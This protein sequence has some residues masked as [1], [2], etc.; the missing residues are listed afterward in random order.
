MQ[1]LRTTNPPAFQGNLG[2][3]KYFEGWYFKFVSADGK[4]IYSII[5]GISLSKDPHAFIQI[6][7]GKTGNTDY[8]SFHINT[9]KYVKD[10]FDIHIGDNHFSGEKISLN[11]SGENFRI[12]GKVR[13][14]KTVPWNGSFL[15]PGIMGWYT[16]VP[17]MECYHGVVSLDHCLNG[18]MNINDREV[19]FSG[20]RGY[21]EKDWGR[22]FPECW[23]WAQGNCFEIP[24]TSF[25]FSV[26]KIPW[27]GKFFIGHIGFLLHK[28]LIYKFTTWNGSKFTI[29]KI[30]DNQI[31]ATISGKDH[32]LELEVSGSISGRLKAPVFGAM[33]RYIKESVDASVEVKLTAKNGKEIFKGTSSHAGLEVVGNVFQYF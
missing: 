4:N 19:D 11:L 16:W 2:R 12:N 28:G 24:G 14:E 22:S 3:R 29:T 30:N 15:S 27:M 23:V 21:I 33:E 10:Q 32:L 6:I 20:G 25:M 31:H 5:P 17:F 1:I 13:F 9:F 7:E 18:T 26:A 8:T